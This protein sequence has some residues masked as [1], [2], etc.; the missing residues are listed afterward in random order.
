MGKLKHEFE[1]L[2]GFSDY[3]KVFDYANNSTELN[4]KL[5]I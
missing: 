2:K 5:E 1:I 3:K 4:I